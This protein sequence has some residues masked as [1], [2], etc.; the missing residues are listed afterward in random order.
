MRVLLYLP[1]FFRCLSPEIMY[2]TSV[3]SAHS[4]NLLSSG[5]SFMRRI[6][7]EGMTYTADCRMAVFKSLTNL[8]LMSF[9]SNTSS[10]SSRISSDTTNWK[11][12]A[13]QRSTTFAQVPVDLKYAAM[14]I[15]VSI[16]TLN[17]VFSQFLNEIIDLY[18]TEFV[19]FQI[20]CLIPDSSSNAGD[21]GFQFLPE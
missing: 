11:T 2:F 9:L 8:G 19:K 17:T 13:V 18:K 14:K 15:L 5:S 10:Y 6:L 20:S 7:L 1:S 3:D 21:I 4:R 12:L 16:I